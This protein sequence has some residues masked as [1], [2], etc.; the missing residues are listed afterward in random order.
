MNDRTVDLAIIGY[1]TRDEIVNVDRE[2]KRVAYISN[3]GVASYFALAAAALREQTGIVSLVG[4]DFNEKLFDSLR[5]NPGIDLEGICD[6][7]PVTYEIFVLI[8]YDG[9]NFGVR[10]NKIGNILPRHLPKSYLEARGIHIGPLVGEVPVETVKAIRERSD[11]VICLDAQGYVRNCQDINLVAPEMFDWYKDLG[12][13]DEEITMWKERQYEVDN[14]GPW[15]D[16]EQ[17]I[18]HMD[19]LKMNNYEI[20]QMTGKD[21]HLQALAD[22]ETTV[23]HLNPNLVVVVTLGG[24][25]SIICYGDASDR[26]IVSLPTISTDVVDTIGGG[27]TYAAGFLAEY[28]RSRDAVEAGRYA[29]AAASLVCEVEGPLKVAPREAVE[30]KIQLARKELEPQ[31][32]KVPGLD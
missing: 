21:D 6:E 22:L 29:A 7:A 2:G 13:T 16:M 3:G 18:P 30:Q 28:S 23:K 32:L 4:P 11:A 19:I 27:D 17:F 20:C 31:P 14:P 5:V 15:R 8:K 9:D 10:M 24:E 26:Q 12:A 1:V 25:G